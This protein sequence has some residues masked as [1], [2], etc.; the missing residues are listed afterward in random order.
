MEIISLS[1]ASLSITLD[2]DIFVGNAV[3]VTFALSN[4]DPTAATLLDEDASLGDI[5]PTAVTFL[6][7]DAS[8]GDISPESATVIS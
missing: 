7:E 8:L 4:I 6:D 5:D 2:S 1:Q 3:F